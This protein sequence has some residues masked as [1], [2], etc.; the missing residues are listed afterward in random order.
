MYTWFR[1]AIGLVPPEQG[2]RSRQLFPA[3]VTRLSSLPF[4]GE[5]LRTRLGEM[6]VG[7]MRVGEMK[8]GEIRVGEMSLN[9]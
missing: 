3:E 7:K 1:C 5:S 8:V 9:Q 2:G 4:R 6:K